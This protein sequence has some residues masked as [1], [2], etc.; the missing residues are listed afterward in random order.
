MFSKNYEIFYVMFKKRAA[1]KVRGVAECFKPDNTHAAS[2]F[3]QLQTR[4][5]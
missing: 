1:V 4:L 2:F 3:E 5:W